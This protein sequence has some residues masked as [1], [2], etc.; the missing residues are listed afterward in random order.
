[1][2]HSYIV[3]KSRHVFTPF[4]CLRP[5]QY[6]SSA[7]RRLRSKSDLRNIMYRYRPECVV[8]YGARTV[9][10]VLIGNGNDD[11]I[12]PTKSAVDR[13]D[14]IYL[15]VFFSFCVRAWET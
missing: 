3:R 1:M 14:Y 5:I 11:D 9:C 7:I 13:R 15:F 6:T 10:N 2:S 12:R 4:P 8:M